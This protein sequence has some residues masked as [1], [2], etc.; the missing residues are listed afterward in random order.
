[1]CVY[2]YTHICAHSAH[3]RSW[4]NHK[5]LCRTAHICKPLQPYQI[6]LAVTQAAILI[7]VYY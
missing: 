1:M 4:V 5:V 2:I 3:T 6:P 7:V